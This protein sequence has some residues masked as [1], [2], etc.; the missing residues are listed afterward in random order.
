MSAAKA[1]TYNQTHVPRKYTPG[2]RRVSIYVTWSYP[3]E[4]NRDPPSW[5][6]GSRR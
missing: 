6:T 4:A 3:G 2:R 5:T 1:R